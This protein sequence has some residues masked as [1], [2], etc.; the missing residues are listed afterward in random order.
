MCVCVN[1]IVTLKIFFFFHFIA[2][3]VAYGRSWAR[4][5]ILASAATCADLAIAGAMPDPLIHCAGLGIEP[6]PPQPPEFR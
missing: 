1:Y 3:P 2:T 5:R 6:A 4:D